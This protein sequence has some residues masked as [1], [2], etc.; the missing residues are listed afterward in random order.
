MS[1]VINHTRQKSFL[2]WFIS[3][4]YGHKRFITQLFIA[5]QRVL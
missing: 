1:I 2:S 3:I 4:Y 5:L